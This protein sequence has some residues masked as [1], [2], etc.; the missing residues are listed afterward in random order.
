MDRFSVG[1][2]IN[3]ITICDD[4]DT[5]LAACSD[6]VGRIVDLR[7]RTTVVT[8]AG[9]TDD[10]WCI[11]A[12]GAA[13]VLTC[14]SDS[15]A[16]RWR[17]STG[18]CVCT[19]VG[20]TGYLFT[21][22]YDAVSERVFSASDDGNIFTWD[23]NTGEQK[24]VLKGHTHLVW[25]I[26]WVNPTTIVSSSSDTTMKMWDITTM[27]EIRTMTSHTDYVYSVATSPDGQCL[28]SGSGDHTVK[29]WSVATG[30]C[31]DT[32]YH[33]RDS[34][35]KVAVSPCG[36]FMGSGG[37]DSKFHF[38]VIV[39]PFPFIVHQRY[40]SD[41]A[42]SVVDHHRLLSDGNL[43]RSPLSRSS[44]SASSSSSSSSSAQEWNE[45]IG[46]VRNNLILPQE[47]RSYSSE[48]MMCR[49]RFDTLQVINLRNNHS[50]RLPKDVFQIIGNY[51]GVRK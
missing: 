28:I 49:Y 5:L 14:S 44:A 51:I 21:I 29:I 40:L 9:H 45:A 24:G 27:T 2:T 25:S 33:P 46:A 20:H 18:E 7:R 47:K 42:E 30:E 38:L 15:T 19:F 13:D 26:A 34:V 6:G 50:I 48:T 36:R 16:R 37:Y 31:I 22:L 1:A 8:L 32:L 35:Y 10:V 11:I 3:G 23:A 17:R 41:S 12:C 43:L 4:G 39:P